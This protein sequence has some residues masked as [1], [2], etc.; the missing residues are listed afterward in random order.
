MQWK[1][2]RE[3]KIDREWAEKERLTVA[4]PG[5]SVSHLQVVVDFNMGNV[6]WLILAVA[7][8]EAQVVDPELS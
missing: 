6:T 8:N 3:D 2:I 7:G 5:R 4:L 1:Q